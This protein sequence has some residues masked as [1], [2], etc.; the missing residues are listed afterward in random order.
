MADDMAEVVILPGLDGT[1]TLLGQFC[2]HLRKL[3]IP[4]RAIAYPTDQALGYEELESFVRSRLPLDQSFVLLGESF[5]GPLAIQIAAR[6]PAGLAGLILSTTFA[7]SPV[8]LLRPLAALVRF[9][10]FRPPMA[11]LSWLLLG[12]WATPERVSSVQDVLRAVSPAVL[13][14]RAVAALRVDVASLLPAVSV[15]VLCLQATHDRLLAGSAHRVLVEGLPHA[16]T[17]EIP[18]PHFLLQTASE[19]CAQAVAAFCAG[20]VS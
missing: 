14:V 10:P 17:V 19:R 15:P 13:R 6:A 20:L 8:P 5:S 1:T 12:R 7:R 3:G 2:L 9:A 16:R 18:G 11:V 4:V